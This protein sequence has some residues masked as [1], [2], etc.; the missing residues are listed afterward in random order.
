MPGLRR[1][2]RHRRHE[3][4]AHEGRRDER[5]RPDRDRHDGGRRHAD[6]PVRLDRVHRAGD[7]AGRDDDDD[8]VEDV[9]D[10][11][12]P[13][14]TA[15]DQA[16][17]AKAV[18][19]YLGITQKAITSG[20]DT[21]QTSVST[22]PAATTD[23]RLELAGYLPAVSVS[24]ERRRR[25]ADD[26][27]EPPAR[28]RRRRRRARPDPARPA[29]A[30]A[31]PGAA[32]QRRGTLDADARPRRRSRSTTSRCRPARRRPSSRPRTR[33]PCRAGS[34]RSPASARATSRSSCA[35]GSP[36]TRRPWR[37]NEAA[38]PSLLEEPGAENVHIPSRR[39]A[40]ILALALGSELSAE[41]FKFLGPEEIDELVLEIAA[42]DNVSADEKQVVLAGVLDGR[43][44]PGL[45]QPG[46][47]RLREGRPRARA[48]RREG[49]RDH[50][51]PVELHP[52]LAVRVPAPRRAAADLQL[53]PER[54]PADRGA[55]AELPRER[56]GGDRHVDVL[57][58]AAGR[59]RD[60]DRRDGPH[61]A[62][63]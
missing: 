46:R 2:R 12:A 34:R 48:R 31:A 6:E 14:V 40:A 53:P 44:G 54:A 35:A 8:H 1:R 47:H 26:G 3:L 11:P 4:H 15:A 7:G 16:A 37:R 23:R 24:Q 51:A 50:G 45:H 10:R 42:L 13:V 30:E 17:A 41:V 63:R 62:R 20:I 18:Q 32:R 9:D 39:K 55:R 21:F 57:A 29:L 49:A 59:G 36:R 60:A 61:R 25:P 56:V 58:R 52:A 27:H 33:R 5:R 38:C 22:I 28:R 43:T 19:A